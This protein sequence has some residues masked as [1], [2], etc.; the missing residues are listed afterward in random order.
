[1][2][3]SDLFLDFIDQLEPLNIQ[4]R[5]PESSN[6]LASSFNKQFAERIIQKTKE[7][8]KWISTML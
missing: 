2:S 3:V 5:Y 6:Q 4:S 8:H 7:M 1:M